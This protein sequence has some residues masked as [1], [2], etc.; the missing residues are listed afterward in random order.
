MSALTVRLPNSIHNQIR[1]LA[2]QD[3]I[4]INQFLASAAAE[5]VSSILTVDYLKREAALASRQ[6]FERILKMVPDV[7]PCADDQLNDA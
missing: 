3:G 6:D 4:S 1:E 5:K 2:K 7:P